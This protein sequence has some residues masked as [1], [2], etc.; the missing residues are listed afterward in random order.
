MEGTD[1]VLKKEGSTLQVYLGFELSIDNS[2]ELRK[3]LGGYRGQD[4]SK[5]VFD[6]T[7]L[8]YISSS[9][10]RAIIFAGQEIGDQPKIEFVNCAQEIYDSFKITGLS[11][12]FS[13]VEDERKAG[14]ADHKDGVDKEWDKEFK[15][16]RQKQ[17]DNYAA[18]NDVVCYQ[19]KLG[20]D[21]D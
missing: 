7:D 10:I 6:A 21:E 19:M 13:F 1:F 14:N 18:H 3:M 17:L 16:V 15:E 2:A 9:G 20:G 12:F 8:V 4:I 5:I 11:N